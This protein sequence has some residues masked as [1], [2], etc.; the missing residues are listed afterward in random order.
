MNTIRQFFQNIQYRFSG[1]DSRSRKVFG[2]L[3]ILLIIPLTIFVLQY[4]QIFRS[5]AATVPGSYGYSA[6]GEN[7]YGTF[8]VASPSATLTQPITPSGPV[9]TPTHT[10]TPSDPVTTLTVTPP[11]PT[12]PPGSTLLSVNVFLHTIGNSGDNINQ[13]NHSGSNK[14]PKNR[15][16]TV[17][18]QI[19]DGTEK[20]IASGSGR[21]V[22]ASAS[23]SFKGNVSIPN[24]PST[25]EYEIKIKELS[26]LQREV[27]GIQLL[28][29]GILNT[30]PEV[31]LIAGDANGDNKLDILDF[32]FLDDCFG[33]KANA[34]CTS[35]K[36]TKTDFDDNGVVD[37][38]DYNILLREL[39]VQFG[40]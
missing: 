20:V 36:R 27:P 3:F 32:N 17:N 23:G 28:T 29:K 6:F 39:G 30:V 10:P 9:T 33:N 18:V 26:R 16:R 31:H 19:L 22:Y 5:R 35:D 2:S 21:I 4:T 15:T 1:M 38:I 37:F 8:T 40:D 13:G 25:G 12:P 11:I 24:L 14:N 7:V 34:T